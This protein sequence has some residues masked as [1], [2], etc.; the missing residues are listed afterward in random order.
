MKLRRLS[1]REMLENT[2]VR[3]LLV[4][5]TAA[6]SS[7]RLLALWEDTERTAR[8]PTPSEVLGPF[9]KKGAPNTAALRQP[10]DPGFPLRVTGKVWNTRGK[11]VEGAQIDI[12]QANYAGRYDVEGYRYRARLRLDSATEYALETVMPGHYSDRP[13]QHI[14]Y[15]ISAPGHKALVTQIYFATDPWFD[16]NVDKNYAKRH[17]VTNRENVRPVT[18]YEEGT[19]HAAVDFDIVLEQA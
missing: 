8:Q 2:I 16:G 19:P 4:G 6:M 13:A 1:R 14:H 5:G 9:F 12:W 10:G 17:I 7:S 15:L 11:P 18:L 3:G